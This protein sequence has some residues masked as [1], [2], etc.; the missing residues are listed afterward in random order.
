MEGATP[1]SQDRVPQRREEISEIGWEL[2]VPVN[3]DLEWL[4]V[5]CGGKEEAASFFFLSLIYIYLMRLISRTQTDKWV[6]ECVS[7]IYINLTA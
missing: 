1:L 7:S 5:I 6:A 4:K 3:A 2:K